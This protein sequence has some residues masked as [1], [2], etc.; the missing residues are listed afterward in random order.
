VNIYQE[1]CKL[2]TL[3]DSDEGARGKIAPTSERQGKRSVRI[4]LNNK[5][6]CI[7]KL[8]GLNEVDVNY[9]LKN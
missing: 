6:D 9:F 1:R 8:N 3:R 4:N 5:G 2:Q 7:Q